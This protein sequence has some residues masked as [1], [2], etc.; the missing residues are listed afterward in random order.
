MLIIPTYNERDN[1]AVLVDRIRK[2]AGNE[3]ILFVDDNS[4]DGTADEIR[5]LQAHDP[6]VHLLAR[7]GK[8]GFGSAC[9]DGMK[10]ILRENLADYMIQMDADLS[11]P[12]ESLPRMIELLKTHPVVIG[13]RYASGGGAQGWD[14]RRH[15]L[16]FGANL[17]ARVLTG[18]PAHDLTAG[19]VGYQ[20]DVLRTI[21]LDAI[22]SEG[23]AFQMEMKFELRR[24]GASFCEFPIIFFERRAGKS[25]FTGKILLEGIRFP[26]RAFR[27]RIGLGG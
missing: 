25:K 10:K 23:Y 7:P 20:A 9:R 6:H 5:R 13:S 22:R 21:D 24:N 15:L 3:P 26:L 18:I 27:T 4:P 2:A 11:H 1:I 12:P 14:F 19:F 16:S 8:G 17:Y